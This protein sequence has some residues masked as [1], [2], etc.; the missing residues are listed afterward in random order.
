MSRPPALCPAT[1]L[2]SAET[3]PQPDWGVA[4]VIVYLQ[5]AGTIASS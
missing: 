1:A 4:V 3:S 5:V 2:H